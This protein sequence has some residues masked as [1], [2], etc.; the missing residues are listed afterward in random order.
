MDNRTKIRSRQKYLDSNREKG[1]ERESL[2]EIP[3]K[4]REKL[5]TMM[6][7]NKATTDIVT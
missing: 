7:P 5:K 3:S 2:L 6:F 1:T 4:V